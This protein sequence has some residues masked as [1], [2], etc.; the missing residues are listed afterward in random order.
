MFAGLV[1][2]F[3]VVCFLRGRWS[4]ESVHG[5]IDPLSD[6]DGDRLRRQDQSVFNGISFRAAE[7]AQDVI[8]GIDAFVLADA[9]PE[10]WELVGAQLAVMSRS[11]F[12]PP[13]DPPARSRSLPTGKLRS[14]QTTNR[15]VTGNL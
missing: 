5:R 6:P 13:S 1:T 10:A 14:S 8:G 15:S 12:C 4:I 11:P 7:P 3:R 9:D 2:W